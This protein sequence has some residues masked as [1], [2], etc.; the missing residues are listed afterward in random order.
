MLLTPEQKYAAD[1]TALWALNIWLIRS[2]RQPIGLVAAG[3]NPKYL[4][5]RDITAHSEQETRP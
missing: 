4:P 5:T 3:V 1:C 2:G